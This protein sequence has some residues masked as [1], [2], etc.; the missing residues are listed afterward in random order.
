MKAE[1]VLVL[2]TLWLITI[3][4]CLHATGAGALQSALARASSQ[5]PIHGPLESK[6]RRF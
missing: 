3:S 1:L 6:Q 4:L 2:E 5:F